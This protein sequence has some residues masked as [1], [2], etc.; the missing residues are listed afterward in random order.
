MRR[1]RSD[2]EDEVLAEA[3]RL[4]EAGWR[5]LGLAWG[6]F[7]EIY[8]I[9]HAYTAYMAEVT[10]YFDQERCVVTNGETRVGPFA[11]DDFANNELVEELIWLTQHFTCLVH[12]S[13]AA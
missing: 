4:F 5:A 10:V 13:T 6:E 7:R 3:A 2:D 1:N 8:V 12:D 9:F 11:V